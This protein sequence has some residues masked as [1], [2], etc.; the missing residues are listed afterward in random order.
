MRG[1][2]MVVL[3]FALGVGCSEG[4][5]CEAGPPDARGL[6]HARCPNDVRE[7][8]PHAVFCTVDGADPVWEDGLSFPVNGTAAVCEDGVP[9]CFFRRDHPTPDGELVLGC[10]CL[11]DG[12][13][14]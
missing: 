11:R 2:A 7:G 14:D 9:R 5:Y 3:V 13:C 6:N 10:H 4:V 1:L 8:G 12:N